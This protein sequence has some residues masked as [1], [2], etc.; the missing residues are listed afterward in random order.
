M[1]DG[2]EEIRGEYVKEPNGMMFYETQPFVPLE[3]PDPKETRGHLSVMT[4]FVRDVTEGVPA[5]TR[6]ADNIHSLAMVL[7]AIE[8]A[9]K[10][11]RV[12][13]GV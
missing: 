1:W 11:Q 12:T 7:G 5:E 2:L 13:V 4:Q 9:K 6:S 10:G 8:S 3:E